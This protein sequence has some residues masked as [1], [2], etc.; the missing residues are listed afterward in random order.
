MREQKSE[1]PEGGASKR[2]CRNHVELAG[3]SLWTQLLYCVSVQMS[4]KTESRRKGTAARQNPRE[5]AGPAGKAASL[6]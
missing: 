5:Y 4:R 3:R 6:T 2:S 1:R